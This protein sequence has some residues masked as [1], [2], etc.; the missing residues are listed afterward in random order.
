MA[1]YILSF[2][3][4]AEKIRIPSSVDTFDVKTFTRDLQEAVK[5]EY[6]TIKQLPKISYDDQIKISPSTNENV[7]LS[8]LAL[9]PFV[10][11]EY[12]GI[13][14]KS[15]EHYYYYRKA[16][17]VGDNISQQ[18]ILDSETGAE[19]RV[20]SQNIKSSSAWNKIKDSVMIQAIKESFLQNP[21]DLALLINTNSLKLINNEEIGEWRLK[22]PKFLEEIRNEFA[23]KYR[24]NFT[25]LDTNNIKF[26]LGGSEGINGLV[27]TILKQ[28]GYNN[29]INFSQ[30]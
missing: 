29:I 20:Y 11:S 8:S 1:C 5:Q 9:R 13:V 24:F 27:N 16:L 22:Y 15:I 12:K 2:D 26:Y 25:K 7:S 18:N 3:G 23:N 14:F 28:A 17:V 4:V 10:I 30:K 19:A 6:Y 21:N